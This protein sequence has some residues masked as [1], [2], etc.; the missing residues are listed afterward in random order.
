MTVRLRAALPEDTPA[1]LELLQMNELPRAG[2][3]EAVTTA[4]VACEGDRIV[5]AAGLEMYQGGA[6]L[7]SVVVDQRARGRGLGQQLTRAALEA[8]GARG[9]ADVYLLTTTAGGFFPKLGFSVIERAEVPESVQQSVE[10][11]GACPASAL[12]MKARVPSGFQGQARA[13]LQETL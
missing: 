6:L 4:L 13:P 7:R 1:I 3:V 2:F 5:G 10:F 11:R 9:V 12:V 8:A